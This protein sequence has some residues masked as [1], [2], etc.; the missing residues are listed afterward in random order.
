MA[1]SE[2][3]QFEYDVF[4]SY[5][6]CERD[7]RSFFPQHLH[8]ALNQRGIK[9][10]KYSE[11]LEKG[12]EIAPEVDEAIENSR[13]ALVILST[14]YASSASCL[15]ELVKVLE[16][17][18][19]IGKRVLVLFYGV[20]PSCV[21][22]Q[23]ES[24]QA[25]MEE[26]VDRYGSSSDKVRQWREALTEVGD[27]RGWI[28]AGNGDEAEFIQGVVLDIET[29]LRQL[30]APTAPEA[31]PKHSNWAVVIGI[32]TVGALLICSPSLIL[33]T[34]GHAGSFPTGVVIVFVSANVFMY[35][36][37]AARI[38]YSKMRRNTA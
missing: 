16:Q 34:S 37:F 15:S 3:R 23:T 38:L 11:D 30:K 19:L 29:M 33:L 4:L 2:E 35:L 6:R 28:L 10:Y 27:M 12:E 22:R 26:H 36:L 20:K 9:S 1:T 5:N 24:Y 14:H 31:S 13:I 25:A 32:L 7:A 18:N 8:D 21:R 17:N